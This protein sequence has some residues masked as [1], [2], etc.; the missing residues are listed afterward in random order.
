MDGGCRLTLF[1]DVAAVVNV[2]KDVGGRRDLL[3]YIVWGGVYPGDKPHRCSWAAHRYFRGWCCLA[4]IAVLEV[5]GVR[6][7]LRSY[8]CSMCS[9]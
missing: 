9:G 5:G 1:L 3:A 8:V 2:G 6:G 4:W 7:W